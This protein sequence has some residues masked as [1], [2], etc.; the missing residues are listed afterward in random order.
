LVDL[1]NRFSVLTAKV[2]ELA[3]TPLPV[4]EPVGKKTNGKK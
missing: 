4:Y 2:D 1:E 3:V